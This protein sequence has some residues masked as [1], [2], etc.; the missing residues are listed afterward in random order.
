MATHLPK[1]QF[2]EAIPEVQYVDFVNQQ[3]V[4]GTPGKVLDLTKRSII[5]LDKLRVFILD[6]ADHML[7]EKGLANTTREIMKRTPSSVQKLFFSAT[8]PEDVLNWAKKYVPNHTALTVEVK[9]IS[10]NEELLKQL[11]IRCESD[12]F[13]VLEKLFKYLTVGQTIIFVQTRNTAKDL[14]RR[15]KEKNHTPEFITGKDMEPKDRDRIIDDFR[16]GKVR[17]LI[18]TDVLSR[19]IDILQVTLVIN[20]DLP[21]WEGVI[22]FEKYLHRIGRTARF[23]QKGIAVSLATD[24]RTEG[25]IK[26]IANHFGKPIERVEERD[27]MR[28][29]RELN[30]LGKTR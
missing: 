10:I 25:W 23:G 6:E 7:N 19:G 17:I 24:N 8:W 14:A 1:I 13:I 18:A 12:P 20:Y 11:Y 29:S 22:D 4:I 2:F 3:V 16:K 30:K 15:L 26:Q 28:V 5:K 21:V 27:L 9:M